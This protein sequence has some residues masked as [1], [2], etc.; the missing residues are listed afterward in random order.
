M[1]NETEAEQIRKIR[2]I[3]DQKATREQRIKDLIALI[4]VNQHD[5][6]YYVDHDD[7]GPDVYRCCGCHE[8]TRDQHDP[9]CLVKAVVGLA[10]QLDQED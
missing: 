1:C 10:L 5:L 7:N 2:E 6:F 8:V 3:E 4:T 9:G